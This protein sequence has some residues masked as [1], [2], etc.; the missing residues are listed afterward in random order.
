MKKVYNATKLFVQRFHVVVSYCRSK[1]QQFL[2]NFKVPSLCKGN[3]LEFSTFQRCQKPFIVTWLPFPENVVLRLSSPERTD[4]W[5]HI[6]N[7]PEPL[8]VFQQDR[9]TA[10]YAVDL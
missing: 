5:C 8:K 1:I 4:Q 3:H 10:Q 9:Q 6:R 2:T 7:S